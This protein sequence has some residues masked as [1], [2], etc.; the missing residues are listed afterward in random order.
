VYPVG[1][2]ASEEGRRFAFL[3]PNYHPRVCGVG[4]FSA[5]LARELVLR[6][7]EVVVHSRAPVEPNPIA[8][9]IPVVGHPDLGPRSIAA[10]TWR[11]LWAAR[12]TDV[13]IQYT[14][15]MWEAWRFGSPA[16]PW[17][18]ARCRHAGIRVFVIGH[19]LYFPLGARPDLVV[20]SLLLRAQ[21]ALLLRFSD[22]VLVTTET[23]QRD[24]LGY[25]R[26]VGAPPPGVIRIGPSALPA[27]R[28]RPAGGA[29]MGVFSSAAVGKRFDVM[30]DAF[31][32]VA[33]ERP[34]A[35]LVL[36]GNLG[37]RDTPRVRAVMDA[38][39]QHAHS[40]RIR[41]TGQLGLGAVAQEIADLDLYF[42]PADTGA[43][44]R[45]STLPSALGTGLPV[46]AIAGAETDPSLFQDRQNVLFA[47]SLTGAALAAGA[48]EV[49]G[50][51]GLAARLSTGA[52]SLY[53]R[54]FTWPRV[55]EQLLSQIGR[56]HSV[57]PVAGASRV[58]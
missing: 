42:F 10:S 29:R 25:A 11:A 8:P 37:G 27:A 17:L 4:D 5:R 57:R 3:C 28:T 6:G 24:I 46:V 36:I 49:L 2:E 45:S 35:E 15:Q 55:A 52:R 19:E 1:R 56:Y 9:E 39:R 40:S 32:R 50:D 13:V 30:L 53:E 33:T 21:L 41:V 20:A 38:V 12:P 31:G 47:K 54:H 7:S 18:A 16:I 26:A 14:P 34:D 22:R 48:L 43:N 44:T 23:R 58:I 51:P